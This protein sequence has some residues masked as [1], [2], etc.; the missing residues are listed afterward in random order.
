MEREKKLVSLCLLILFV[1]LVIVYLLLYQVRGQEFF[2]LRQ[3]G[4]ITGDQM[5]NLI[6]D[7]ISD[8]FLW[9]E[10]GSGDINVWVSNSNITTGADAALVEEDLFQTASTEAKPQLQ[11]Q[12]KTLSWTDLYFWVMDSL[13]V[14]GLDP[15]YILRGKKE[16]Y[17]AYFAQYPDALK[18]TV[19]QLGGNIFS[20]TSEA[21]LLQHGLFGDRVDYVNLPEYKDKL[22]IMLVKVEDGLWLIQLPYQDYHQSKSYLKS[23][24]N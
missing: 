22:V 15:E 24:F 8:S 4:S 20:I 2:Q 9:E 23:L 16:I 10:D 6:S 14:L 3:Q 13:E 7:Q 21:D 1:A 5:K 11:D 19:Q 12:V 18:K 17:F